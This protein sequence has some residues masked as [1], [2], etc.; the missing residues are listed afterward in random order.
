[1]ATVRMENL[2][3]D[4]GDIRAVDNVSLGIQDGE[5]MVFV[6]PSGCG[7][8]TTLRSIAGLEKPTDGRVLFDSE[9]VTDQPP[10]TRDISMVFQDLALYPH[11]SVYDNIAFPLRADDYS[12][13]EI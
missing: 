4:F 2:V 1:M 8:T 6:G 10:Q 11:L 12:E 5:L 7:K 9:E 3:K 13:A